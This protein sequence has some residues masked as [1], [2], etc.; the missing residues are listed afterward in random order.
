MSGRGSAPATPQVAW[1]V[2]PAFLEPM[3]E[4]NPELT[5]LQALTS[6]RSCPAITLGRPVAARVG[7]CSRQVLELKVGSQAAG[8]CWAESGGA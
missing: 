5:F 8:G 6:A 3:A 7:G 4:V 1:Q 2:G